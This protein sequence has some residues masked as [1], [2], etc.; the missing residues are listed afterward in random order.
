[1]TAGSQVMFELDV[2]ID[3]DG[4][5]Q[6]RHVDERGGIAP[7]T[8]LTLDQALETDL[9]VPTSPRA[10]AVT[11]SECGTPWR[12]WVDSRVARP[13]I[14]CDPKDPASAPR[15]RRTPTLDIDGVI[16]S[17][18]QTMPGLSVTQLRQVHPGD[19]EGIWWFSVAGVSEDVH[20]ESSTGS[21]PF[22]V[23]TNEQCCSEARWAYTVEEAVTM[24]VGYLEQKLATK[25]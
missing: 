3:D 15:Y 5:W 21:C 10:Q 6:C 25:A 19:D 14:E 7:S 13:Y 4:S 9:A 11:C 2:T 18:R 17:A 20:L 23:E 8:H 16:G 1:M 24:V 22:I 12:V